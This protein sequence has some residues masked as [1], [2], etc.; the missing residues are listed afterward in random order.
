MKNIKSLFSLSFT[1]IVMLFASCDVEPLDSSIAVGSGGGGS[2]GGGNSTGTFFR[3]N[4]DGQ[5]WNATTTQAIVNSDYI[6]ITGMRGNGSFFQITIPN[7]TIGT[8][9]WANASSIASLGLIYSL[10]SGQVPYL[11][12]SN[13]DAANQGFTGYTDT[14]ELVIS[15]IN[16]STRVISGTFKFTGVRYDSTLTQ[17]ETKVFTSGQFSIP[18]TSNTT[19]PSNNSFFCKLNGADYITT[20]VD[21]LS[22]GGQI[23]IV[24]RRGNVE[25]IGITLLQNITPGTYDLENLPLGTNNIGMYNVDNSGTNAYGANPGTVTITTHDVS[26]K[27]IVGTF[28]FTGTNFFNST[29]HNIS[30]GTFDVYYQ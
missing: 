28:Q 26:A 14:A 12:L 15:S 10:G 29:I 1:L 21:G 22:L 24:G 30:N 20:N 2:T 7:G 19:S 17:T 16:T 13:S 27:H 6:A 9:N 5:T 18:Y 11:S 8:Y 25:N 3:A 23:N 4:F